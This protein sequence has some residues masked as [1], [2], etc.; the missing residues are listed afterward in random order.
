MRQIVRVT[1]MGAA[2][3]T[4]ACAAFADTYTWNGASGTMLIFR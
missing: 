4:A 2:L 1:V 3:W